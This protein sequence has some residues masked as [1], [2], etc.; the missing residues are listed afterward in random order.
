M[1]ET[2]RSQGH[3]QSRLFSVCTSIVLV[4]PGHLPRTPSSSAMKTPVNPEEDPDN[5]EGDN[6]MEYFS[7]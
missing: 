1:N 3:I 5:P 2:G 6:Q 7:D 4:S